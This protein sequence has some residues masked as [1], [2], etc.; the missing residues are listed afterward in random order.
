MKGATKEEIEQLA[1]E[2]NC[3]IPEAYFEYLLKHGKNEKGP[4]VG[5]DCFLRHIKENNDYLP[6]L[7]EDNNI[8]F[9]LPEKYICFLMH[10]GYIAF[11][12]DANDG[13]DPLCWYYSEG[14]TD[15]PEPET[16]FS[17]FIENLM[18]EWGTYPEGGLNS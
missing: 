12:F 8:N 7:L 2:L 13:D 15:Y 10:Q 4:L 11:W 16:S 6:E 14:T 17:L 3:P 5:S 1:K 9:E 18:K